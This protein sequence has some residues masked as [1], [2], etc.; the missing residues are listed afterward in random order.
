MTSI[1]FEPSKKQSPEPAAGFGPPP[2]LP[3]MTKEDFEKLAATKKN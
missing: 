1:S 2:R 3:E